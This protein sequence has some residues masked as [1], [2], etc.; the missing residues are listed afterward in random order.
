MH[1]KTIG[2]LGG[3]GPAATTDFFA[4]LVHRTDARCDQDHPD[5]V[6]Y[7]ACHVPDRTS[8]LL[9]AGEDPTSAL[10][11]AAQR[12]ES[13]GAG[14]LAIP[15]NTAHA[16]HSHIQ[17]AVGIPVMHMIELAAE[18]ARGLLAGAGTV[19]VLAAHGT[20]QL[21]LYS[22]QLLAVGL[23]A[24]TPNASEVTVLSAVVE[25]VKGGD[26]R[27]SELLHRVGENLV[28]RGAQ[29]LLLG[30]TE[31]PLAFDQARASV[32]TVDA[33]EVL[34]LA[35]LREAGV[36]TVTPSAPA[37]RDGFGATDGGPEGQA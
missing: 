13:F 33:T 24:V 10:V 32:S 26:R 23:K 14:V 2:V 21:G 1:H 5:C 34:A 12:L 27:T 31:L 11:T 20:L 30:C 29:A 35:T 6:V 37:Q 8:H 36:P 4:R 17:R 7:N 25:A 19:G 28:G 18:K 3:M 9:E 15:C 16:Y 22:E